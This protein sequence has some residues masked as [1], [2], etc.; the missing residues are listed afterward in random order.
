MRWASPLVHVLL[1]S[2]VGL[3]VHV[4]ISKVVIKR[5]WNVPPLLLKIK[6][7]GLI[8]FFLFLFVAARLLRAWAKPMLHVETH[9][10]LIP[11]CLH[12]VL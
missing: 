10:L 11:K 8:P 9:A 12:G 6:I 1:W 2:K 7:L 5:T 4:E 3:G